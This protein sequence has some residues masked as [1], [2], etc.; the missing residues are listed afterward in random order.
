VEELYSAI[1]LPKSWL[2]ALREEMEAEVSARQARTAAERERLAK[3][4]SRQEAERRKLLDAYYAGA[5]DVSVLRAEQARIDGEARS[6]EERLATLDAQVSE[7]CEILEV[8]MAFAT[9]CARAYARASEQTRKLFNQAV[10]KRIEVRGGKI[11]DRVFH[12][13]FDSLFG[14]SEFEYG[15]LVGTEGLE[16]SLE[17][18]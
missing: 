6:T 17:A 9:D 12:E 16:P 18:F 2:E 11:A 7:W 4:H 15:D 13:P 5:I 8:A 14:A 3:E 10:F 1:E